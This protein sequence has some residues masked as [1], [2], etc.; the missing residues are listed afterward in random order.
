MERHIV[1]LQ[2]GINVEISFLIVVT[3]TSILRWTDD[4]YSTIGINVG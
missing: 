4:F 2:T 3:V 1:R